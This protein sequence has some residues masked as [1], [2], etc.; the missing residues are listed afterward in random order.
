VRIELNIEHIDI[1]KALEENP[2]P[3]HDR[4]AGECADITEPKNGGAVADIRD[5]ISFAVY[6]YASA[7]LVSISWQF[8]S[9]GCGQR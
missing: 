6:L 3:F 8:S 1:S 9:P 5:K 4:F 2:F 7:G